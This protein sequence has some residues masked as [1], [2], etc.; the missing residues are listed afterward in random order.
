MHKACAGE[1]STEVFLAGSRG[2]SDEAMVW[3]TENWDQPGCL[4]LFS[5]A[6][7]VS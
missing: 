7:Q 3:G 1:G 4:R 6:L 5:A 2:H